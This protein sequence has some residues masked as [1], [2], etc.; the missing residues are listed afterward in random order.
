M[1][2]Y[3][4]AHVDDI[5]EMDDGGCPVRPVRH[6]FG[7]TA[8]GIGAFTAGAAGD[9]VINEHE[10]SVPDSSEE[11]Y[12]VLAIGGGAAGKPYTPRAGSSGS[13]SCR[14]TR[15]VPTTRWPSAGG[16]SSGRSRSPGWLPTTSPAA[17]A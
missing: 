10:E 3:A 9:R 17:R 1:S 2:E 11:L 4:V 14:E 12:L 13:R 7:S 16:R 8:F 5:P 15:R 6:H